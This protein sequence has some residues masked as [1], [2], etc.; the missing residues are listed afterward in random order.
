MEQGPSGEANSSSVSQE[1][2]CILQ[3]PN[4][5][6]HVHKSM[7]LVPNMNQL[8][9]THAT[10]P[11]LI[12]SICIALSSHQCLCVFH[13]VQVTIAVSCHLVYKYSHTEGEKYRVR[14]TG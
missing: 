9:P 4:V 3:N 1:I 12:F 8:N 2:L 7:P 10:V 11:N 5:H 6:C 13:V 14:S